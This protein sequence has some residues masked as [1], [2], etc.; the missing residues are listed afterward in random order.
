MS[1]MF[2]TPERIEELTHFW[3]IGWATKRI[4]ERLGTTKNAVI[5]KAHN[6][7]LAGREPTGWGAEPAPPKF[8]DHD[9]VGCRWIE[10]DPLPLRSGIYCGAPTLLG[11]SW[12]S[13]HKAQAYI[14]PEEACREAILDAVSLYQWGY[15]K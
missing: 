13:K 8:T 2:W 5:S 4:A 15:A 1:H 12:C 3:D 14:N 9:F 6:L 7:Q 10:S 11:E